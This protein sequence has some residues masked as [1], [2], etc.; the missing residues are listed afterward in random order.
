VT[1]LI[2]KQGLDIAE[3]KGARIVFHVDRNAVLQAAH[4]AQETV[5]VNGYIE[6]ES[7]ANTERETIVTPPGTI[8]VRSVIR[9]GKPPLKFSVDSH[10]LTPV[11]LNASLP[12]RTK[13][14]VIRGEHCG[15]TI[16]V[17]EL[18]ATPLVAPFPKP[19]GRAK[20]W[21]ISVNDIVL[22]R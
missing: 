20:K 13:G 8:A 10:L 11:F 19:C 4:E 2:Q 14:F 6:A 5:R 17:V 21:S 18:S 9:K 3:S 12:G 22:L 16:K 15:Q 7:L 1:E